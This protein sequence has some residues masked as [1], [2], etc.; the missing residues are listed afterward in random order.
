MANPESSV[1]PV[2][3][4]DGITEVRLGDVVTARVWFI[5]KKKG[6]VVYLPGVSQKNEEFE[7]HGLRWV[8]I[9]S[10]DGMLFGEIIKP[11]TG[12]LKKDVQ[13]LARDDSPCKLITPEMK[14]D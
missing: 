2:R 11:D 9:E 3:Y 1:R 13:F 4:F 10:D 14:F 5:W 7:H 6:R 12:S 8:A